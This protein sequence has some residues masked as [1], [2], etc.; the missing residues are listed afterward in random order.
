MI[1]A[2]LIN[3]VIDVLG[4][5][6]RRTWP[7]EE[8]ASVQSAGH[9]RVGHR[10]DFHHQT[11]R[12]PVFLAALSSHHR[13]RFRAESRPLGSEYR[14]PSSVVGHCRSVSFYSTL[15]TVPSVSKHFLLTTNEIRPGKIW[16]HDA[17]LLQGSC[18]SIHRFRRHAPQHLRIGHQ[19]E[20]RLGF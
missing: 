20:I 6:V 1:C 7:S 5:D 3:P 9:R 12:S 11:I 8:R 18:G 15:C 10:Q 2:L 13:S 14:H 16:Q 17:C 4:T 19:M